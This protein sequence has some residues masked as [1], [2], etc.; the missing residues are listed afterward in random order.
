MIFGCERTQ[1]IDLSYADLH[2]S[3]IA[4]VEQNDYRHHNRKRVNMHGYVRRITCFCRRMQGTNK[5]SF[6]MVVIY[7]L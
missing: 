4:G 6:A 5:A 7:L 3:A 1:Y 2:S